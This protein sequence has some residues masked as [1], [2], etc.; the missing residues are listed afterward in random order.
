MAIGRTIAGLRPQIIPD[1]LREHLIGVVTYIELLPAVAQRRH[2]LL[3]LV[4]GEVLLADHLDTL[5]ADVGDARVVSHQLRLQRLVLLHQVLHPD[6]VATC[7]PHTA[8]P[9]VKTHR[10]TTQR[11]RRNR[12]Q[13]VRTRARKAIVNKFVNKE[14]IY[15]FYQ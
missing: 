4:A 13:L 11:N 10:D 9:H 7:P 12:D 5:L 8:P 2:A 15:F 1:T 3:D 14:H 6:Q